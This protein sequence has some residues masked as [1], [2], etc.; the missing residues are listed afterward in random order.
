[1]NFIKWCIKN[2]VISFVSEH[3]DALMANKHAT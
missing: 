2:D 3:K 1:L